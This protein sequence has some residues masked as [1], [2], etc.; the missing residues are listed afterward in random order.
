MLA[1]ARAG[2]Q[3]AP[4]V[5]PHLAAARDSGDSTGI[6]VELTD[7]AVKLGDGALLIRLA[8][9]LKT[10]FPANQLCLEIPN[11]YVRSLLPLGL[12]AP[13]G[14]HVVISVDVPLGDSSE[15][16][17]DFVGLSGWRSATEAG[18]QYCLEAHRH[19]KKSGRGFLVGTIITGLAIRS[20]VH[21]TIRHLVW[22]SFR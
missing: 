6:W 19:S 13:T 16:P 12:I 2:C 10:R 21:M 14:E 18:Y 1:V 11:G 22:K 17:M 7:S 3:Q 5:T 4:A 9:P 20:N 15:V 8:P